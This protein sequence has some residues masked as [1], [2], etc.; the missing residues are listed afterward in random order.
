[1]PFS[2][3]SSKKPKRTSSRKATPIVTAPVPDRKFTPQFSA[4]TSGAAKEGAV[5]LILEKAYQNHNFHGNQVPDNKQFKQNL[6]QII[7]ILKSP[8]TTPLQIDEATRGTLNKQQLLNICEMVVGLD[9]DNIFANQGQARNSV[10]FEKSPDYNGTPVRTI[11]LL[12]NAGKVWIVI[13]T[14]NKQI[15][16]TKLPDK[17]GALGGSKVYKPQIC[18]NPYDIATPANLNFI[19]VIARKRVTLECGQNNELEKALQFRFKYLQITEEGRIA[20]KVNHKHVAKFLFS[21]IFNKKINNAKALYLYSE[22]GIGSLYFNKYVN[23]IE[24]HPIRIHC[25]KYNKDLL[26]TVYDIIKQMIIS[27]K[28]LHD[29]NIGHFDIKV[30]NFILYE[31]INPIT[32]EAKLHIKIDDF[33]A[34]VDKNFYAWIQKT[35]LSHLGFSNDPT[36]QGNYLL[37]PLNLIAISEFFPTPYRPSPAETSISTK[38]ILTLADIQG[39]LACLIQQH[40]H[41]KDIARHYCS[42]LIFCMPLTTL[43]TA[44]PQIFYMHLHKSHL[45]SLHTDF[46]S[47]SQNSL[48]GRGY[49]RML[50]IIKDPTTAPRTKE[51][52]QAHLEHDLLDLKNDVFALGVT[53][54]KLLYSCGMHVHP[55]KGSTPLFI[56][57]LCASDPILRYN[58]NA[59]LALVESLNAQQF[60]NQEILNIDASTQIPSFLTQ[61][62]VPKSKIN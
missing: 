3:K 36:I 56:S 48:G 16:N 60:F 30:D 12:S 43:E 7:A 11:E 20:N 18:I 59:V 22:N 1:M 54:L 17:I 21:N 2:K 29:Q 52:Y 42:S 24:N 23:P 55:K 31:K 58:I 47:R 50:A 13:M 28:S 40:H 41:N 8:S 6:E 33:G 25:T 62:H 15:N 53:I 37:H 19:F 14:N 32:N 46:Y 27:I 44:S 38:K 61:P 49:K 45:N 39:R 26:E 35:F 51:E 10:R 4:A 57:K 9:F 34:A 5:K